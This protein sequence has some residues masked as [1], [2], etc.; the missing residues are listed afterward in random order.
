MK[1]QFTKHTFLYCFGNTIGATNRLLL[2][3]L[4]PINCVQPVCIVKAP[5][6]SVILS[7]SFEARI[8]ATFI[9]F[10]CIEP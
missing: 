9:F 10:D 5:D 1:E 8:V 4:L 7:Y 6:N 2:A 3:V